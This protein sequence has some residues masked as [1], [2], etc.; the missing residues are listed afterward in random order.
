LVCWNG[1][2]KDLDKDIESN[3]DDQG[4][5][6]ISQVILQNRVSVDAGIT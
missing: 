2:D 4:K 1:K 3:Q 5:L 6:F